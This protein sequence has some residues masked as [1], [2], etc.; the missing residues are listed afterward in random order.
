MDM[1]N[2]KSKLYKSEIKKIWKEHQDLRL[3]FDYMKHE[4]Y[5]TIH[6]KFYH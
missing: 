4:Y 5:K 2:K 1:N 3:K 6:N